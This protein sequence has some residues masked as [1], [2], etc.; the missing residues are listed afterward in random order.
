MNFR[1][2]FAYMVSMIIVLSLAVYMLGFWVGWLEPEDT[3]GLL[4]TH[5]FTWGVVIS[6]AILGGILFGMIFGHRI[7]SV[8]GFT[9]IERN[10]LEATN[11]MKKISRLYES[12]GTPTPLERLASLEK[13][14]DLL[15]ED[16]KIANLP[17][18]GGRDVDG[19]GDSAAPGDVSASDGDEKST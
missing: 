10:M 1:I 17:D 7:L 13:K 5:L 8:K 14:M 3:V 9:P 2:P 11:E 4:Q 12:H 15:L 6:F 16:R 19:R 18:D